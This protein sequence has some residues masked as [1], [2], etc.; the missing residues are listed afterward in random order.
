MSNLVQLMQ[1]R[2]Q[3]F[4]LD[5][6]M[7]FSAE[8]V[9]HP[10]ERGRLLEQTLR[11]FLRQVMPNRVGFGSGQI[12]GPLKG[13]TSKQVD[14]VVYD[15][16]DFPLLL[17]TGSYQLFPNEAVLAAVEVKSTLNKRF[18]LEA[19][20][21]IASVKSLRKF[22]AGEHPATLGIVFCYRTAWAQPKTL[23]RNLAKGIAAN[24]GYYPDL[25]CSLNP[26][27]LLASTESLG[28]SVTRM[29]TLLAGTE[30]ESTLP[31]EQFVFIEPLQFSREHI[32]LWFY[33][34]VID[35]VNRTL[36]IGV[37]MAQYIKAGTAWSWDTVDLSQW[38]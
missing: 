8:Q 4:V 38:A 11:A 5:F 30:K 34:L 20:E 36:D 10:G 31:P 15:V 19:V 25:I 33:L 29:G 13:N 2:F 35:Y 6:E 3:Q 28:E 23:F 12:V 26:G 9:S 1:A 32:L 7:T 37:N 24:T 17:D 14:I 27:Y 22:P 16:L 21:N 18:L